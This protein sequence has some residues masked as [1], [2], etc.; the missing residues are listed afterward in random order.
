MMATSREGLRGSLPGDCS[1]LDR[2]GQ[3]RHPHPR[4]EKP[5]AFSRSRNR[6]ME[7]VHWGDSVGG[8]GLAPEPPPQ[9]RRGRPREHSG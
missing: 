5:A 1:E 7:T 8:G 9:N 2:K 4:P 6:E 3:K